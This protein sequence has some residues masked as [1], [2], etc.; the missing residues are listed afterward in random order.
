[1][2]VIFHLLNMEFIYNLAVEAHFKMSLN[3]NM[4]VENK[5]TA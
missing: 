1:M 5:A 3:L 4:E 2:N